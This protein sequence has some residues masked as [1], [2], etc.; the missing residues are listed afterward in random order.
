MYFNQKGV[1][2]CTG[3]SSR[4]IG[5]KEVNK[6]ISIGEMNEPFNLYV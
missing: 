1:A 4:T 5:D 3:G 2:A 6:L